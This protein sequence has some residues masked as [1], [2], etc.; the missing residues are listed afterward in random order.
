MEPPL[1]LAVVEDIQTGID[2]VGTGDR[3]DRCLRIGCQELGHG[4]TEET[5]VAFNVSDLLG[6][7]ATESLPTS[8]RP[9]KTLDFQNVGNGP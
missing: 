4:I 5:A 6:G 1:K 8:H 7:A 3:P 2:V 9:L